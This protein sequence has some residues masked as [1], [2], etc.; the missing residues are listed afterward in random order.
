MKLGIIVPYRKRPGHLRKFQQSIESYLKNQ[1]YELIVVEQSDDLPFNRGKLLNIGFQQAIRKQCDYVVF[2]DVDMLPIN[3]DYSYSDVPLHLANG[4][5]NSD[6]EIFDTYFGGVTLFPVDLFK[7]VNGYS[8]E[9]WGWGFEDDDLLMRLTEQNIF[10]DSKTYDVPKLNTSGIYLHGDHSYVE[11]PNTIELN[12]DFTLHI[13]FRPDEIIP[14][15]DKDFDEYCAF[16]IPG[17]DTTIAYNSFNRYKF[18]YWDRRKVCHQ[19]TSKYSYPQ[20]TNITITFD[21]SNR[22]LQ[23]HQDGQLIEE[24]NIRRSFLDTKKAWFYLGLGDKRTED[25]KSFRG[26]INEFAYWDKPLQRNEIQE[27]HQSQGFSLLNSYEQYNSSKNLK[28]YYDFKHIKLEDDYK[29]DTGKVLNLATN[30]YDATSYHSIPKT[31]H[32]IQSKTI[33]IPARRQ[34]TFEMIEH[35]SEGYFEGGWKSESTRLNQLRFYNEILNNETNLDSDGLST[36]KYTKVS[37]TSQGKYSF[38]SVKL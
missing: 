8:N 27:I 17:W 19:I 35:K 34:S 12:K 6:R 7:K 28:I 22:T 15:Y 20:Y 25:R 33:S 37:L 32:D 36:L 3:V 24:Q 1:D 16:S 9:Y 29:Y 21:K 14:E 31:I 18:E 5:T 23:M 26:F 10:T 13:S 4:F 38:I 2:H 30:E 11:C